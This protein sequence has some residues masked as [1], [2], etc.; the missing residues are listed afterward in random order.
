SNPFTGAVSTGPLFPGATTTRGFSFSRTQ[1]TDP[2]GQT[3]FTLLQ[4]T[5]DTTEFS[6]TPP[7]GSNLSSVSVSGISAASDYAFQVLIAS[8]QGSLSA[9][10]VALDGQVVELGQ[11]AGADASAGGGAAGG[12]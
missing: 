4:T 2:T 1:T 12:G 5:A 11:S 10:G 8:M 7:T 9:G 3:T 6:V